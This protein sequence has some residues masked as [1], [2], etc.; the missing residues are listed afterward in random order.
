[1]EWLTF[2]AHDAGGPH[3]Y[4]RAVYW[5]LWR[6]DREW[7]RKHRRS[8]HVRRPDLATWTA[9]DESLEK[10]IR[11]IAA[12]FIESPDGPRASRHR[13]AVETGQPAWLLYDHPHLPR[14]VATIKEVSEGPVEY[15]LRRISRY[16]QVHGPAQQSWRIRVACGI[17][18]A[19]ARSP[20]VA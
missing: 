16:V 20:E 13:I 8:R 18:V 10:R 12:S 1:S 6:H 3:R 15:A 4:R 9:R 7:L 19:L 11:K 14:A 17:S 5:W 2:S